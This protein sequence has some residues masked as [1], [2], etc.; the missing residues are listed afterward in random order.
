MFVDEKESSPAASSESLS[1]P[2]FIICVTACHEADDVVV[3]YPRPT[4]HFSA[5]YILY[6]YGM[7]YKI[8]NFDKQNDSN[9]DK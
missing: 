5:P 2:K 6:G 4:L 8:H 7:I 3:F 9:F 1:V